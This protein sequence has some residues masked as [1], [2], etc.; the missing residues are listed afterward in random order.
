M[1]T[2]HVVEVNARTVD[3]ADVGD[4]IVELRRPGGE[5]VQRFQTALS[6]VDTTYR[7]DVAEANASQILDAE[8]PDLEIWIDGVTT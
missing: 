1:R 7:F 4:L 6:P 2:G 5:L 8:Y 3:P